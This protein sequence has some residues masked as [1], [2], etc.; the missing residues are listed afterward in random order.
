MYHEGQ[1]ES[2]I[3]LGIDPGLARMGFAVV[4]QKNKHT[5]VPITYG[6]L[7]TSKGQKEE[8]RL[9]DLYQKLCE[10]F[11]TYTI[12][13]VAIEQLVFASNQ[14]TAFEVSQARGLVYL[15]CGQ[16]HIPIE[17]FSP[18]QIKLTVVGYGR[19]EKQQVQLMVKTI[20]NL[21]QIPKLDDTADA[22]AI[23]Y[24]GA[25]LAKTS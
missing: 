17:S 24:T 1:K 8:D 19:A 12:E 11:D 15:I 9:S 25:V 10:I 21:K 22:L 16:R 18:T 4:E 23:A 5:F 20:Y 6:C 3:I 2:M 13:R 7:E 14:T